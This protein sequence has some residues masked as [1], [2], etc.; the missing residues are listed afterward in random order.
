MR[1]S[2]AGKNGVCSNCFGVYSEF[3]ARGRTVAGADPF[4]F[5]CGAFYGD[6]ACPGMREENHQGWMGQTRCAPTL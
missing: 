6:R 3:T 4:P 5:D 2:E 1:V